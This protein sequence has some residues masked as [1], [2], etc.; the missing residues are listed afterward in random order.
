MALGY[1]QPLFLLAFDH[2]RPHI[3]TLFGVD[4]EPTPQ[5]TATIVDA[6][7]VIFDGFRTALV[8]GAPSRGAGI[9]VDEQFGAA[10]ARAALEAGQ[11]C[12]MPVERSGLTHFDFEYGDAFATHIEAFSPTLAKILVRYNPEGDPS[13][14]QQSI[15]G[16]T[17]LSTWLRATDRK[18]LL[19][20][21]VPATPTQL[22]RVDGDDRRYVA[23]VRP[24]LMQR[25]IS[26]LQAAGIEADVWKIEGI[27][28]RAD[29]A[30]VA[31]QARSGGRDRVGCVVLGQGADADAGRALAAHLRR[32]ARL[33]GVRDRP[34]PVVEADHEISARGA[35]PDRRGA[36][37][38]SQLP[39]GDRGLPGCRARLTPGPARRAP[40]GSERV[41]HA[42]VRSTAGSLTAAAVGAATSDSAAAASAAARSFLALRALGESAEANRP[43]PIL[44]A[45]AMPA[46]PAA[47][48]EKTMLTELASRYARTRTLNPPCL[49]VRPDR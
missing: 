9:L 29:C 49:R 19:E 21:I 26:E 25:A 46:T 42:D 18:L 37:G 6:K 11:V 36:R 48:A 32:C 28:Q 34:H 2:R 14:N 5:Q 45:T 10:V 41:T 30:M 1:E 8:E 23:E 33:P 4:G 22:G 12:A 35:L 40:P 27:D 13:D 16:M 44:I 39:A 47:I 15:A 17:R 38:V 7:S 3:A 43:A 20:L 31:A 24:A